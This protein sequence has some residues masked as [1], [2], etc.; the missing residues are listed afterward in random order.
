MQF[1]WFPLASG[2]N[3]A[4]EGVDLRLESR[5]CALGGSVLRLEG[6]GQL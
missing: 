2:L 4:L 5:D 3:E 1:T 6:G